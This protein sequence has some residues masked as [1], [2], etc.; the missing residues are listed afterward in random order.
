MIFMG[1]FDSADYG[2]LGTSIVVCEFEILLA[3][4]AHGLLD[5]GD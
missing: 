3:Q 5:V 4:Y 1:L 2:I